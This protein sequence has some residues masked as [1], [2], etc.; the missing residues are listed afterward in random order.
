MKMNV[1]LSNK[2]QRRF[3][4]NTL[5]GT[6]ILLYHIHSDKSVTNI[7]NH[8]PLNRR[9]FLCLLDKSNLQSF[10]SLITELYHV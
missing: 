3:Y 8:P 7:V 4:L 5:T 2:T 9:V 1:K 10:E 6:S